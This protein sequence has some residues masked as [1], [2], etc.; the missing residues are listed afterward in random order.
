ML[1]KKLNVEKVRKDFPVLADAKGN[2]SNSKLSSKIIYFDSACMS[3]KP[4]QVID[5]VMEYYN[6]YTACAGRS[7]HS[8]AKK[9]ETEVDR[10]RIEVRK[11]INAKF[12]EEII[13]TRNTTEGINLAANSLVSTFITSDGKFGLSRGDEVIISDKEHNS[14]LIPWLKLRNQTGIKVKIVESNL[15]NTFNL[16]N[17]Q[18]M[19]TKKTKLVS[20]V[21]TSNMDGVTNPIKD[22][23]KI[24]REKS[25][26]LGCADGDGV[27]LIVDGAQSVPGKEVDVRKLDID[28][29]SFSGH[30][31]LGPTGTG[32]LYG[33]KYLLEKMD[34]FIVGGETVVDSTYDDYHAEKLPMKFE[35]GL[36]DYAGIIG[37][38]EA[39][40][41]LK[42][43]GLDN[44]AKHENKLNKQI[45]ED[46]QN[47]INDGT[48][49]LIG[50]EDPE[51]R[52]GIFSFNI[53][54]MDP[55]HISNILDSSKKIMTRSGAHCVHSWF[56]KP[57]IK[58]QG[59]KGSCRASVYL[60]NT[61]EE[62]QLFTDEV[63]KIVKLG[64]ID[65]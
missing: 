47:F 30:K 53:K 43:V 23:A 27:I 21:H 40:R 49:K 14:N 37:L 2:Y 62:V 41:Y 15:D 18:K 17:F 51:K 46:L 64:Y 55:H 5:K 12:D 10:T 63:K 6:E 56:N 25:D 29:L 34:Q 3:L 50:P 60:Y 57:E 28:I 11:L 59:I 26:E 32:V 22:I 31:M 52:S 4:K 65:S 9:V 44:I 36:Q 19:F 54:G 45:T 48:I 13:F 58:K 42:S 16:E 20:L 1:F 33:K 35:A 38:S 8:S 24:T 7:A 61:E 39:C